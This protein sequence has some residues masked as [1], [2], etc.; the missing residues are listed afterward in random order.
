[1]ALPSLASTLGQNPAFT[2]PLRWA[3]PLINNENIQ[4]HKE[5]VQETNEA[6]HGGNGESDQ[7]SEHFSFPCNMVIHCNDKNN[8]LCETFVN[9]SAF[10]KCHDSKKY[11]LLKVTYHQQQPP[12][13]ALFAMPVFMLVSIWY[14]LSST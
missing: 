3:I 6:Y 14:G 2:V 10:N 5:T 8:N 13:V 11:W 7:I 1:M 9:V 12:E 4:L